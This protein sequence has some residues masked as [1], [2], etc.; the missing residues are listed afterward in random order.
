MSVKKDLKIRYN[1]TVLGIFWAAVRPLI[2]M[3]VLR[4]VFRK[5]LGFDINYYMSFLAS[6]FLV[7]HFFLHNLLDAMGCLKSYRRTLLAAPIPIICAPTSILIH[8]GITMG[9]SMALLLAINFFSGIGL[10][11]QFVFFPLYILPLIIFSFGVSLIFS[12]LSVFYRDMAF[13]IRSGVRVIYYSLPI[14]YSTSMLN[15]SFQISF[16]LNPLLQY[17]KL[18]RRSV[19]TFETPQFFPTFYAYTTAIFLLLVGLFVF[20]KLSPR[21]RF[22]E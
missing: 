7:W 8:T 21:A 17:V 5:G 20:H 1:D 13:I 16:K 9:I 22:W 18:F 15:K 11:W 4:M 2:L 6:G 19:Y 14:F 10:Y 3:L 12:V